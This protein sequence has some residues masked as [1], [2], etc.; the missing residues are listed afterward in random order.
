[1]LLISFGVWARV[2]FRKIF[3]ALLFTFSHFD[4]EAFQL[5]L[6]TNH[7]VKWGFLWL[8]SSL[9]PNPEVRVLSVIL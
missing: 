1:V 8:F 9:I 5:A 4:P 7:T 6:E 3:F 2:K